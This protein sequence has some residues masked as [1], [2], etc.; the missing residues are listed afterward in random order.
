MAAIKV[1]TF[2]F[3]P[4]RLSLLA[5]LA[6]QWVSGVIVLGICVHF[7]SKFQQTK[8]IKYHTI[9]S[10]VN[11]WVYGFNQCFAITKLYKGHGTFLHMGFSCLWLTSFIFA[12]QDYNFGYCASMEPP[13][14]GGQ[15]GIKYA[16]EAFAG[17]AF[18]CSFI[19]APLEMRLYIVEHYETTTAPSPAVAETHI[20]HM[21]THALPE[22]MQD[23]RIIRDD[24][25]D[26]IS[27]VRTAE[28]P[29]FLEEK[30]V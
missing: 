17:V 5:A 11:T 24:P 3:T 27:D 25:D 10:S 15:C 21:A 6:L 2:A 28:Q 7:M 30:T 19:S 18:V 23:E 16:L 22:E 20:I 26:E 29:Y 4:L 14:A 13:E 9:I 1:P 12:V 8:H